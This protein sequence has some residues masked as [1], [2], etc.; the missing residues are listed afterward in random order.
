M[1]ILFLF[2]FPQIVALSLKC[3]FVS[4]G[5]QTGD[6]ILPSFRRDWTQKQVNVNQQH[7]PEP[8]GRQAE[9]KINQ[10]RQI[11]CRETGER[12]LRW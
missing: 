7:L 8:A 12:Q 5:E 9:N 2:I 6:T 3:I 11:C 4:T 10:E 1:K